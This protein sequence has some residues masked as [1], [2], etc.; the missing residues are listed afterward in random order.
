MKVLVIASEPI[1]ADRLRAALGAA[2]DDA[3]VMVVAP[4][5]HRSALRFW[6]SDA[7]EA[8]RRAELVQRETVEGFDDAGLDAHGD[9]GEGDPFKAVEDALVTFGAERIVLFTRP[10]SD[11]RHD[12]GIDADALRQKFGLPVQRAE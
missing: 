8:I 1:S 11:Q 6:L 2:T 4:A 3:E 10:V 12:E 7:D 5:L 9:T